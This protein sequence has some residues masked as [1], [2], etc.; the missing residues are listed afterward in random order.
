MGVTPIEADRHLAE[1]VFR[2]PVPLTERERETL[3][4]LDRIVSGEAELSLADT[5]EYVQGAVSGLD[6]RVLKRLRRGEFSVQ[7]D[8][9]LHGVDAATA[10]EL[11]L[12]LIEQSSALG[13]RCVRIVH[14]RG[15]NSPGGIA[16]LKTNLPRW[17][18][19]GSARRAVLA[20]TSATPQD[21]GAG[22]MYVLLRKA[23]RR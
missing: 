6:R 3:L 21:G 10:R 8:L 11:V 4:E 13:L 14:G 23:S 2:K 20:Y 15:R 7:A 16:V 18:A 19:R 17:L 9:D 12:R 5:D 22:A 1:P